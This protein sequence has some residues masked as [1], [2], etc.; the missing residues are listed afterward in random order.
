MWECPLCEFITLSHLRQPASCDKNSG[1]SWIAGG[2][3]PNTSP[4]QLAGY[5]CSLESVRRCATRSPRGARKLSSFARP[6]LTTVTAIP[7]PDFPHPSLPARPA[8]TPSSSVKRGT[9]WHP[10]GPF[11]SVRSRPLRHTFVRGHDLFSRSTR[12]AGINAGRL[13]RSVEATDAVA[14]LVR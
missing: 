3:A 10:Q 9:L 14:R 2:R 12:V 11:V 7:L 6:H 13:P 4:P 8:V 1:R 5:V